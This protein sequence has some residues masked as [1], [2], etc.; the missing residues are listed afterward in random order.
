MYSVVTS[1]KL[2]A[3]QNC[4]IFWCG[5]KQLF[6]SSRW[7]IFLDCSRKPTRILVYIFG[8]PVEIRKGTYRTEIRN[9][10]TWENLLL[11]VWLLCFHQK[12]RFLFFRSKIFFVRVLYS[13]YVLSALSIAHF[14]NIFVCLPFCADTP[15]LLWFKVTEYK[16]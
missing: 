15:L 1:M 11:P 3:F 13:S 5:R 12:L 9:I 8:V 14:L 2:S 6:P 10:T 4:E 7:R 16:I